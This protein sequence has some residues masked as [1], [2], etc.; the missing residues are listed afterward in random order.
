MSALAVVL[1]LLETGRVRVPAAPQP[2]DGLDQAVRELDR[3]ARPTLALDP[4]V[5]MP[6]VAEWALLL[7]FRA[8]QSL[9]Y[10]EIEADAVTDALSRPCLSVSCR[11]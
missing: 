5:L 10:R 7:L 2:P 6:A 3:I 11:T 8:C 1:N 9:V 4:P